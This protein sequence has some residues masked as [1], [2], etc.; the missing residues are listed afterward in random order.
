VRGIRPRLLLLISIFVA[1]SLFRTINAK[2][3]LTSLAFSPE[4]AALYLGTENGK[5]LIIDLR[6]LDKAPKSIVVS[7]NGSRVETISVQVLVTS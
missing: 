4:G 7:G 2:V 5:L 1:D 6:A 3:P